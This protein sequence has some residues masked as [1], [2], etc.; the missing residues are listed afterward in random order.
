M[1]DDR[2]LVPHSQPLGADFLVAACREIADPIEFPVHAFVPA[3]PKVSSEQLAAEAA[4][5]RLPCREQAVLRVGYT[6]E[7][8]GIRAL[9]VIHTST[10]S[11]PIDDIASPFR[12]FGTCDGKFAAAGAWTCGPW[13]P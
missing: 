9:S 7:A 3:A 11:L 13:M 8:R 10:N 4:L 6:L 12:A 1:G 2:T 5:A